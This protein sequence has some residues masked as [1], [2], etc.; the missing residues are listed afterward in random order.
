M[1]L[2]INPTPTACMEVHL[3]P[4]KLT[5]QET[6]SDG[7]MSLSTCPRMSKSMDDVAIDISVFRHTFATNMI[8]NKNCFFVCRH[9]S[10]HIPKGAA[11]ESEWNAKFAEYEKKYKEEAEVLKS[12]ITGDLPAGWEKALPVS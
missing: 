12:I 8:L 10:R 2:R 5:P 6:I 4:K 9:W 7:H 1:V 3:V 11:V